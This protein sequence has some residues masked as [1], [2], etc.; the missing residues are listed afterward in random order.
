LLKG[1][2]GADVAKPSASPKQDDRSW[3]PVFRCQS[4]RWI[5]S[6]LHFVEDTG[7]PPHSAEIRGDVHSKMENW[8][9]AKKISIKGYKPQLLGKTEDEAVAGLLKRMDGLI[10]FSKERGERCRPLVLASN[11]TEVEP[12]VLESALETARVVADVLHT[13]GVFCH[14]PKPNDPPRGPGGVHFYTTANVNLPAR[15]VILGTSYSTLTVS[16]AYLFRNLPEG[17]YTGRS[18]SDGRWTYDLRITPAGGYTSNPAVG[19]V[20][21]RGHFAENLVRNSWFETRWLSKD[22]P[23]CWYRTKEG[24]EGELLPLEKDQKYLLSL[25]WQPDATGDV[26]VRWRPNTHP[27][28]PV[29]DSPPV[30]PGTEE[31]KFTGSEKF[32]WA[33]V[34]IRTTNAPQTLLKFVAVSPVP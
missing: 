3:A 1:F 30:K 12:I 16:N 7:S 22:A 15:I 25:S 17:D 24:W 2:N 20:L 28:L 14:E 13:F 33:Q 8:V 26:I 31:L 19:F 21:P 29:V 32:A 5:G 11:R 34:I 9:D 4:P 18:F 23:D 10:A 27:G 6:L